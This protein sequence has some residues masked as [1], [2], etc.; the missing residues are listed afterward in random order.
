LIPRLPN[1]ETRRVERPVIRLGGGEPG[2]LKHLSTR[3]TRNQVEMPVV[4]ASE[5]GRAQTVVLVA[6][7]L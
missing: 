3:R 6:A 5:V 2:E 1:G 7:G 4:A